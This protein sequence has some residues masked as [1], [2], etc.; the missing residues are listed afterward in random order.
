MAITEEPQIFLRY[1][2]KQAL[3]ALEG[4]LGNKLKIDAFETDQAAIAALKERSVLPHAL[5]ILTSQPSSQT[6]SPLLTHARDTHPDLLKILISDAVP[7]D[8]LVSLLEKR[9]IDRCFEQPLDPDLVRSHVLTSA[10]ARKSNE[11]VMP[12]VK[13]KAASEV[14]TVLIVDDEPTAT[15]YLARQLER[16]QNDFRVLCAD[17]A[18]QAL[19]LIQSISGT[20]AVIMTDQRMPGM[21]GKELLDELK[22]SHPATV[23]ILTSAYGEVNV[24]LDAVNEGGIFRYQKKPWRATELL[25]L[26]QEAI[27]RHLTLASARENTL[28]QLEHQFNGLRDK[29]RE[30]LLSNLSEPVDTAAGAPVMSRFLQALDTIPCLFANT[31]HLRASLETSLENDLIQ[32]FDEQV[33]RQLKRL[34]VAASMHT[35]IDGAAIRAALQRSEEP[36]YEHG[37]N[38]PASSILLMLCEALTTLLT[39][40]GLS[41]RSLNLNQTSEHSLILSCEAPLKLYAHL[42]APLT[43]LSRPFLDQ[44]VALLLLFVSTYRLGGELQIRGATQSYNLVLALPL[45]NSP[46]A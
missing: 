7:L 20:L 22:Q 17:S 36:E 2:S 9:L 31:S 23:R 29:R 44:Q 26:F 11:Y 10:L 5:F 8:V 40:S 41:W 14:P 45:A 32:Q 38:A 19:K 30:L 6:N 39:A 42:L 1:E 43:R 27:A 18:E 3:A 4:E 46:E 34:Q 35:E 13:P 12:E 28:S 21:Q 25:P 15:K 37:S 33:H 24:A 16:M